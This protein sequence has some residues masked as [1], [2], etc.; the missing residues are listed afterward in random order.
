MGLHTNGSIPG[1]L[2][3]AGLFQEVGAAYGL[4]L[5]TTLAYPAT[6]ASDHASF[7][8][9]GYPAI[10]AIEDLGDFNP[11]YHSQGDTLDNL[12]DLDYFTDMIKGSLATFAHLGCLI[13]GSTG[14]LAGTFLDLETSFPIPGALVTLVNQDPAWGYTLVTK[15]D[16]YGMYALEA[17]AGWHT[18][19][20]DAYGYAPSAVADVFVENDSTTDLDGELAPIDEKIQ[21][22]PVAEFGE[23][24][25]PADC[26]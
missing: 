24:A 4:D 15:T 2:A 13:E 5:E 21:Y 25:Q 20:V 6:S 17:L 9:Y 3:I 22:I 11:K 1:S 16:A 18:I 14:T 10:L 7:W 19:S 12:P 26:P 23:P 8:N